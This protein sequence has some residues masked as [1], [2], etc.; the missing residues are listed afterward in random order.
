MSVV[1][2]LP[3][4]ATPVPDLLSRSGLRQIVKAYENAAGEVCP[5][6]SV[7]R[8]QPFVAHG[9]N[10]HFIGPDAA[11]LAQQVAATAADFIPAKVG[12]VDGHPALGGDFRWF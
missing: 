3:A 2:Q 6:L 12:G 4:D 5:Q 1:E 9:L 8:I 11:L 10:R 7:L